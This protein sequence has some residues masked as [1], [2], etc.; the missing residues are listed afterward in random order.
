V[1]TAWAGGAG[2]TDR[3]LRCGHVKNV[4]E[5]RAGS[6]RRLSGGVRLPYGFNR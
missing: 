5:H 3:H 1:L 2:G 4:C 6:V